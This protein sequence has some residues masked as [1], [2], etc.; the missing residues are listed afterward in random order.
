MPESI[1]KK[2]KREI[3]KKSA[4]E[5]YKQGLSTREIGKILNRSHAWVA[6]VIKELS[7]V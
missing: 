2:Q 4:K 6:Y 3:I 5:L 1:Y 7:T